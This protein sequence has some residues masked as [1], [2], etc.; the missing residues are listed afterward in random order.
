MDLRM[1]R[2]PEHFAHVGAQVPQVVLDLAQLGL[3]AAA[4]PRLPL[5]IARL[6]GGHVV[7]LSI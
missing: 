2:V 6:C 7:K 3:Q 4:V 1:S 5:S